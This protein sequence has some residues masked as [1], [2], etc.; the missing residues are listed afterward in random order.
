MRDDPGT[1]EKLIS[2]RICGL[3]QRV[4]SSGAGYYA[5]CSRCATT[6]AEDKPD[7]LNRT[8]A[9]ASSALIL[10][11][12]ANLLPIMSFEYFGAVE[13]NTVWSGVVNLYKSGMWFIAGVVFMASIIIPL[14]KLTI[15]FYLALSSKIGTGRG[16]KLKTGLYRLIRAAG[17]WAM[18]D[19]FMLAILVSAVKLGQL[20]NISPGPGAL[21]FTLV[22]IFSILAGE[23]FDPKLIWS[24]EAAS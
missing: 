8:L 18:L 2:C 9:F 24:H 20:A 22:V 15:L 13:H 14:V 4:A 7:S 5:A 11:V 17:A 1:A 21:P 6:M 10:Y 16:A 3:V 19:V 23:S 12:P